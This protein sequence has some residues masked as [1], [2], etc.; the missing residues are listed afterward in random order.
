MSAAIAGRRSARMLLPSMAPPYSTAPTAQQQGQRYPTPGYL[1][2]P[3]S[4]SALGPS[5]TEP[6]SPVKQGFVDWALSGLKEKG[7]EFAANAT[8]TRANFGDLGKAFRKALRVPLS[9]GLTILAAAAH[10]WTRGQGTVG[11]AAGKIAVGAAHATIADLSRPKAADAPASDAL[12]EGD[13]AIRA[14]VDPAEDTS[15]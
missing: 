6:E 11:D 13:H 7:P 4:S 5:R 2:V 14:V 8:S 3:Q 10:A 12:G 15:A 9:F 1:S